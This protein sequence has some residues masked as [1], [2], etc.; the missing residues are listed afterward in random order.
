MNL[1][2][3][4]LDCAYM[5]MMKFITPEGLQPRGQLT[6]I[7]YSSLTNSM[8]A[9]EP[10]RYTCPCGVSCTLKYMIIDECYRYCC[11]ISQGL[12]LKCLASLI[13]RPKPYYCVYRVLW[14]VK[15]MRCKERGSALYEPILL[16]CR[17]PF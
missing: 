7:T 14:F 9:F 13:Q 6:N 4:C 11:S 10:L 12:F 2:G 1:K 16:F 3:S 5:M 17:G 8:N 15:R